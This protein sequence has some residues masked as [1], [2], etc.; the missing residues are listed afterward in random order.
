MAIRQNDPNILGGVSEDVQECHLQMTPPNGGGT[1]IDDRLTNQ[2]LSFIV[3]TYLIYKGEY[4]LMYCAWPTH[5][6]PFRGRL[7]KAVF[8]NVMVAT[9]TCY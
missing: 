5:L 1:L 8:I 2:E 4:E 7:Q 6:S 9:S 3:G